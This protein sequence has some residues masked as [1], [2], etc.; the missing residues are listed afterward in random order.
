MWAVESVRSERIAL[1]LDVEI[2]VL[3]GEVGPQVEIGVFFDEGSLAP[4]LGRVA[5]A[6]EPQRQFRLGMNRHLHLVHRELRPG[7][8]MQVRV[9]WPAGVPGPTVG[10]RRSA[11]WS[12][13]G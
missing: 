3:Q 9:V 8:W 13:S 1:V 11:E 2:E 10:D 7:G 4:L 6:R 5:V 12:Q